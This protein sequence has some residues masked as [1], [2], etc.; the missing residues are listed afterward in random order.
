MAFGLAVRKEEPVSLSI[1]S[2]AAPGHQTLDANFLSYSIEFSYMLDYAGNNSHPNEFSKQLLENIHDI[3]G[4]YP[5]IRAGGSTSNRAVFLSNQS[6][7]LVQEF[8]SDPDQPKSLS[9]GPAWM[10]SFQQFPKDTQYIYGLN[11][12]DGDSGL[13]KTVSEAAAAYKEI[14]SHIYAFEIGNEVNG[15]QCSSR[16]D[17]DYTVASY[18]DQFKEYAAAIV[19]QSLGDAPKGDKEPLFQG[20]AFTAPNHIG[21][22]ETPF[23]NVE[24]ALKEGLDS[25]G[26]V[27]TV[28]D[29]DYMGSACDGKTD[30]TIEDELLNHHHMTDKMY[31]HEYL[32]NYSVSKGVPY[33][34][35]ETNSIS[36]QGL[37]NVSDVYAAALWSVD[38]TLYAASLNISRVYYHMGTP[39]RYSPWQPLRINETAAH[40]KPLYYG[41]MFAAAAFS[42]GNKQVSVLLNESSLAAYAIYDTDSESKTLLKSVA[43]LNLDVWNSTQPA[44]ERPYKA[45]KLPSDTFSGASVKRLTSPGVEIAD[46][47]TFAGQHV[48]D[49]GSVVGKQEVEKVSDGEV[50]VAAGEAVLV[51]LSS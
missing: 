8:G 4:A 26:M 39:Y 46:N 32:G 33:V 50:R 15:F 38:Y 12:Y 2:T 51:T 35:G 45:F 20:C 1:P 23:W 36:C 42:G 7:A 40:V 24:N 16:R 10:E 37:A 9:I 44:D 13:E 48:D 43:M 28:A 34:L 17:C 49:K 18:A 5:I 31:N 30:A 11:F 14:G 21:F 22:N 41:N 6:E 25:T 27:K 29:H 3:S 19:K 47:I